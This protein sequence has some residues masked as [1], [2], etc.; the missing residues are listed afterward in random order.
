MTIYR[1]EQKFYR[2]EKVKPPGGII[3][4]KL[5]LVLKGIMKILHKLK[6]CLIHSDKLNFL[7]HKIKY[8]LDKYTNWQLGGSS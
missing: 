6:S 2:L 4:Q 1:P 3:K 8:T 7:W 5:Q